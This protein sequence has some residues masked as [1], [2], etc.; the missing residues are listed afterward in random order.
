[1]V[2]PRELDPTSSVLAFFG[3]E[4]RR[5]R[6]AAGLSQDRLGEVVNYTGSLVGQVETARRS[7][8]R[9]FAERVDA[10]LG[11]DGA[12]SR[13]WPLVNRD[14]HPAWFR[15]YVQ[16][17]KSATGIR[18][19]QP[20]VVHGLLQTEGYARALLS[21]LKPDDLADRLAAR[22]ERQRIL[23][24]NKP[25][26]LWVILDEAVLRRT[27][28]GPDVQRGQLAHLVAMAARSRVV[29]Q[30]LPFSAGAHPGVDGALTLLSF[31]DE[32]DV[33]YCEGYGSSQ[34]IDS[35]PEVE[36]CDFR[37][38]LVRAA[39]LSPDAS[40]GMIVTVMEEL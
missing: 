34:L 2:A 37:Y 23:D 8:S 18:S 28:G 39:A 31:T 40:V 9:D 5:H 21:T 16:L 14:S 17:E 38:D 13:L 33:A 20:Q 30:V 7:P 6:T 10:A 11:T 19:F 22:L 29:L 4:L 32:Q 36:E 27:V 1:M 25:P 15:G 35:A 26:R 24:Q 12:L 3:S